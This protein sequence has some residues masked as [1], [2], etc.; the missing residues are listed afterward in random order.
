[1][2]KKWEKKEN[3]DKN[4]IKERKY[5]RLYF[6]TFVF[7]SSE[8]MRKKKDKTFSFHYEKW[9]RRKFYLIKYYLYPYVNEYI[10]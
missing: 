6:F 1:M 10:I 9:D 2:Q 7:E 4:N 8:K 5:K 3:Q